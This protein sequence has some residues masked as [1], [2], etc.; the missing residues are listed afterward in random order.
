MRKT[1]WEISKLVGGKLEGSPSIVVSGIAG[2]EN[3]TVYDITFLDSPRLVPE[4]SRTKAAAV[5]ITESLGVK[6]TLPAIYVADAD[7]AFAKLAELIVQERE[8]VTGRI[9]PNAV[10][11]GKSKIGKGVSI[12]ACTV[13]EDGA[14]IGDNTSIGPLCYIGKDT[15]IGTACRIHM[16]VVIRDRITVGDRCVIH[17]GVVIG[18]DGFGFSKVDDHY[19]KIPQ[20]GSVLIEDDVEIGANTTI[21]RARLDRTIIGEGT[22]I[23]N[24]CMIGHSVQ[25]GRNCILVSQVGI[26][27]SSVIGDNCILAGQVGVIDH[28]TLASNVVLTAQSGVAKSLSKPGIYS[29]SPARE[30]MPYLRELASLGKLPELM[31]RVESLQKRVDELQRKPV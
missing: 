9:H 23:D 6:P 14:V 13:I 31:K 29:G 8:V 22:K 21:D 1:L 15:T 18:A 5:I 25:I 17:P 28:V 30:Q 11:S 12:G 10:I 3:A 16:S 27:G 26:A 19:E 2:I 7:S 4:L 20:V 24:L